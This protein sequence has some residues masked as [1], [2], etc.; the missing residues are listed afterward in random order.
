M[1]YPIATAPPVGCWPLAKTAPELARDF[2]A[3]V[4][5]YVHTL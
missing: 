2:S 3:C 5:L 4:R 1:K